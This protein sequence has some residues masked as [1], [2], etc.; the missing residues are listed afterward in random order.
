MVKTTKTNRFAQLK[1]TSIFSTLAGNYDGAE[2]LKA[3][4]E[5]MIA[6]AEATKAV[7]KA[8]STIIVGGSLVELKKLYTSFPEF[9]F[10]YRLPLEGEKGIQEVNTGDF[11]N[12]LVAEYATFGTSYAGK[13][14]RDLV[15]AMQML[16]AGIPAEMVISSLTASKK[17]STV[18]KSE[19][20]QTAIKAE[21]LS[22]YGSVE[23]ETSAKISKYNELTGEIRSISTREAEL[24]TAKAKTAKALKSLLA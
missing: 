22:R 11:I 7:V 1:T 23:V 6:K 4:T 24:K 9:K 2:D 18:L 21:M 20:V 17:N 5:A 12:E 8:E 19:A 13:A 3:L 16:S 14:I 10:G 15:K